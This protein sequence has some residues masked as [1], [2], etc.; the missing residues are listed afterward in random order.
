MLTAAV[1]SFI[2]ESTGQVGHACITSVVDEFEDGAVV[3]P[4]L[5]EWESER[6]SGDEAKRDG[7]EDGETE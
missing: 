3:T 7:E 6:E 4:P 5:F 2:V 1:G